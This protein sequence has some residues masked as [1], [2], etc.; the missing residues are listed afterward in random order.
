MK[1]RDLLQQDHFES[2]GHEA[3]LNVIATASWI[4]GELAAVMEPGRLTPAQYNVL[5]ILRGSHPEP[6]ACSEI[7]DRLLDRTPDVT[8]LLDRLE[9]QDLIVR[10]RS[11]HD[12]RVVHVFITEAGTSLL[13]RIDPAVRERQEALVAALTD[14]ELH[15]LSELLERVRRDQ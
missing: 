6:M 10:K 5:R 14:D 11:T 9:K 4:G 7:R 2:A 8:R 3:I 1:L 12:R 15:R 13:A